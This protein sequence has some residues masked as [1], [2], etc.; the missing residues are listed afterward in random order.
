MP[1]MQHYDTA[2]T[3]AV[4]KYN[5]KSKKL[6]KKYQ[7]VDTRTAYVFGDLI[8]NNKGEA[9]IS[10]S[11]NNII[12]KVNESKGNL[13]PFYSNETFWNIQGITFSADEQYLFISDYIK[14]LFR[15]TLATKE[16]IS[17]TT[18]ELVSLKSIDGLHWYNNSLIAI[19]N[20]I[21]P[22]RVTRYTLNEKLDSITSFEILDRAHP[23]FNEPTN[24]CVIKNTFLYVANSQWGGYDENQQQKPLDQLQDIVILKAYLKAGR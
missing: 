13:E 10:D 24:G 6:I 9:F 8:L 21:T 1:E 16:L 20:G 11:R 14:G 2:S 3:S 19:Q 12:F 5:I 17:I 22:M 23:A 15:L 4:F 18:N 7:P